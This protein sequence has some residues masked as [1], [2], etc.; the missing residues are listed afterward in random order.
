MS[1]SKA[2]DSMSSRETHPAQFEASWR[3]QPRRSVF[4]ARL[5]PW[6]EMRDTAIRRQQQLISP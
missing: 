3:D 4:A 6:R 5:G 1:G 2:M